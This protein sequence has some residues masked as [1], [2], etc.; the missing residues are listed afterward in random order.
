MEFDY[1]FSLLSRQPSIVPT[2]KSL[3]SAVKCANEPVT[4]T[5]WI[6]HVDC[7]VPKAAGA[8]KVKF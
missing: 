7:S 1:D 6:F 2:D 8:Q 3:S 4:T 5:K